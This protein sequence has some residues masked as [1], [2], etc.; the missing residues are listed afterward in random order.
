MHGEENTR[1][2]L[3]QVI[4]DSLNLEGM[5]PGEID[6]EAP[7]FGDEGLGLDS[8]DALELM[9]A[10]EKEYGVKI[11]GGEVEPEAFASVTAMA[12]FVERLQ[13]EGAASA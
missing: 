8:V 7:L 10:L 5:E 1:L 6:D 12:A 11:E 4:V 9:V 3:K 2:R 13:A